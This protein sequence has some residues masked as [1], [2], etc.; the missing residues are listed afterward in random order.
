MSLKDYTREQLYQM[1]VVEKRTK[2]EIAEICGCS[3]SA[4]R[5]R[6]YREGF[7]M[8]DRDLYDLKNTTDWIEVMLEPFKI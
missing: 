8:I 3:L 1:Y 7:K 5:S 4:I 6:L 2:R